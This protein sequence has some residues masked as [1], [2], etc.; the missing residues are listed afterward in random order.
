MS[1]LNEHKEGSYAF[2]YYPSEVIIKISEQV[3]NF[4]DG[5][6]RYLDFGA[7]WWYYSEF[8]AGLST[9]LGLLAHKKE[10]IDWESKNEIF[11][12]KR[13]TGSNSL[14]Q[15]LNFTWSFLIQ[16]K[17]RCC[18]SQQQSHQQF[19]GDQ[20]LSDAIINLIKSTISKPFLQR[21][22]ARKNHL[23]NQL[24]P[25]KVSIEVHC[26]FFHYCLL[27]QTTTISQPSSRCSRCELL[28]VGSM[29]S[30]VVNR[31]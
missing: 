27:I 31:G 7:S 17:F 4:H 13:S 29:R 9:W 19:I 26:V 28:I 30:N 5:D 14:P 25:L 20:L 6:R 23:N 12:K 1:I 8:R 24:L 15:L 3:A 11:R 21:N 2:A 16:L 18:F 22:D 10:G